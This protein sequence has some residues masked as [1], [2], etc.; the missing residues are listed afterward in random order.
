VYFL[1]DS[2]PHYFKSVGH[3]VFVTGSRGIQLLQ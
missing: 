2:A 1:A 3:V